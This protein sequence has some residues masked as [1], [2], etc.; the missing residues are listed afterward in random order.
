MSRILLVDD[1]KV[2]RERLARTLSTR[3]HEVRPCAGMDEAMGTVREW[4]PDRAIVDLRMDGPSGLEVLAWLVREVPGIRAIILTGYGSI[5]TTVEAMRLGAHNYVAKPA[6]V[7]EILAAFGEEPAA[8]RGAERP[9]SLARIEWEIINRTLV[10]CDGN[11]SETAR[12]LG[13]HRRTLQR[14]LS[15]FPPEETE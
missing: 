12:R 10:E 5:A 13:L 3:G 8:A 2:F 9:P 7:E 4:R 14:R 11:V 15:K 1:D 6:D